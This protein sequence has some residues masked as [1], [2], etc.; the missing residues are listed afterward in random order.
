[1]IS[2]PATVRYTLYVGVTPRTPTMKHVYRPAWFWVTEGKKRE[3][4]PSSTHPG[5][6]LLVIIALSPT[7]QRA[8]PS[9]TSQ[10]NRAGNE[11]LVV[12]LLGKRENPV[13]AKARAL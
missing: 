6:L 2:L 12:T 11:I 8:N 7:A 13:K 5:Q 10:S 1:M 4:L 3:L 9:F